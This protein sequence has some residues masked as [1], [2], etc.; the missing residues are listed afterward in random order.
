MSDG[1]HGKI[2]PDQ[3]LRVRKLATPARELRERLEREP[4][5][6]QIAEAEGL[7]LRMVRSIVNVERYKWVKE[8]RDGKGT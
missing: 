7:T 5:L 4:T 6:Q 3:V 1:R 2:P 8:K